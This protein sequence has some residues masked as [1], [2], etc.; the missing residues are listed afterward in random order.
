MAS[1]QRIDKL[2]R[3]RE[4][5][6]GE[7][8][9]TLVA[10]LRECAGGSWG[11]FE[12]NKG[13]LPPT[14]EARFERPLVRRVDELAAE[15]TASRQGLGYTEPHPLIKQLDTYRRQRGSNQLGEQRLAM[16]FLQ[17]LGLLE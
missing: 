8:R 4:A 3:E 17:D 7:Y 14:M 9:D 13:T 10:A 11:L 2:E 6:E 12:R 1:A 16:Q 15:V 5:L